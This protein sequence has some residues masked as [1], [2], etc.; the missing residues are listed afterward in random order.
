MWSMYLPPVSMKVF[1]MNSFGRYI[2]KSATENKL[3]DSYCQMYIVK[4][5]YELMFELFFTH[6]KLFDLWIIQR[7][8]LLK[9]HIFILQSD[10]TVRPHLLS[11][12]LSQWNKFI[13]IRSKLT[14]S[15]FKDHFSWTP[16]RKHQFLRRKWNKFCFLVVIWR[17]FYEYNNS[18]DDIIQTFKK[19]LIDFFNYY[20]RNF[21]VFKPLCASLVKNF[22]L[23]MN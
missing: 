12:H 8:D 14:L 15:L 16:S 19:V 23:M 9:T 18:F 1:I 20:S 22:T 17:R 6:M 3:N 13:P 4:C 21:Y 7:N 5:M 2:F 10:I 11:G